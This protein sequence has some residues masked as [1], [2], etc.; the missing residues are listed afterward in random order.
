MAD[1]RLL[2]DT[3]AFIADIVPSAPGLD[4][5][6]ELATA[7]AISLFTWRRAEGDDSVD[8]PEA[9]L[10]RQGWWAD[11]LTAWQV[12]EGA[13]PIGSRLWLLSRE[14]ITTETLTRARQYA[15]EAL[16]W[17]VEDKVATRVEVLVERNADN[18]SRVDMQVSI[19]RQDGTKE[20]LRYDDVW[21]QLR[22][23]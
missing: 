2:W 20:D 10:A 17:M 15:E 6:S 23:A 12:G 19:F 1:I 22:N 7:A 9:L 16:A 14:K 4:E 13:D 18:I 21:S 8:N 5:S 11:G 3:A